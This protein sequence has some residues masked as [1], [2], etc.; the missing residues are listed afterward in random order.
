MHFCRTSPA[1]FLV[2]FSQY[3]KSAEIDYSIGARFRMVFE[4]EEFAEQRCRPSLFLSSGSH[5]LTSTIAFF[6]FFSS[7]FLAIGII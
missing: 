6:L 3:M 2:P 5:S 4:G 7:P 1:E